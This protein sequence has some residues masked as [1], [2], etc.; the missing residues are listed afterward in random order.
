MGDER[1][2]SRKSRARARGVYIMRCRKSVCE[3]KREGRASL[4][5]YLELSRTHNAGEEKSSCRA[6]NGS[7]GRKI[8]RIARRGESSNR[9]SCAFGIRLRFEYV[10]YLIS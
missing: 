3:R 2:D 9:K 7:E 8:R 5:R 1:R 6:A 4:R 10:H